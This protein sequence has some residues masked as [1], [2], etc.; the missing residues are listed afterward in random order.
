[1][2]STHLRNA[3]FLL[4]A[5]PMLLAAC[6]SG[7]SPEVQSA[8][9]TANESKAESEKAMQTAQQ[10]LQTAQQAQQQAQAANERANAMY[11]RSLK[12]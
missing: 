10:A 8:V 7:P 5:T 3:S 2:R 9:S 4:L 1:M 6:A 12:K 11:N